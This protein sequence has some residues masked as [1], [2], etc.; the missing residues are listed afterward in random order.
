MK[1]IYYFIEN[2]ALW[3]WLPWMELKL[4]YRRSIIGPLW[5]TIAM[6]ITAIVMSLIYGGLFNE[7]L[8]VILPYIIAGLIG[9]TFISTNLTEGTTCFIFNAHIIKSGNCH[10]FIFPI[11]ILM[12]NLFI[13]GHNLLVM[14]IIYGFFPQYLN[15]YIIFAI[16]NIF[17]VALFFLFYN[18]LIGCLASRFQDI[19][20]LVSSSLIGIMMITPIF[21]RSELLQS[22]QY[23]VDYNPFYYILTLLR[24]PLLGLPTPPYIYTIVMIFII[25]QIILF[26]LLKH[27]IRH[28]LTLYLP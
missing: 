10:P 12:N 6:G 9:W 14:V 3:L 22:H 26:M 4:R 27:R 20:I 17:L 23:L 15:E 13:M 16:P 19:P 5:L 2:W 18:V 24:N 7:P 11:K 21:F 1:K 28:N 8:A 25:V